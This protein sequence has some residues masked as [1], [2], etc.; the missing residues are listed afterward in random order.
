[1]SSK[2]FMFYVF[3]LTWSTQVFSQVDNLSLSIETVQ[4]VYL[5]TFKDTIAV[6]SA[7]GFIIRS[8]TRNYLITNWHVVTNKD[9]V[10][11]NWA[12]GLPHITPNKIRIMHNSKTI[13]NHIV[14][15]ENLTNKNGIRYKQFNINKNEMVDV[16]ALPLTDTSG[17]VAIYPVDYQNTTE[18]IIVRPTE[19]L[20]V[21][22]FPMGIKSAPFFPIWKSGTIASEPDFDQENKPIIWLDIKGYGGMSGAPVYLIT[23]R[24]ITKGTTSINMVGSITFFMGVFSHATDIN[25][26]GIWKGAYLKNIF[27]ELP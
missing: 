10:T 4:S 18:S 7:T 21:L 1:M 23:D 19:S 3:L 8:K 20:Y 12:N 22:G 26:G 17:G 14:R 2:R 5:E 6:S 24:Y 16:I 11:Q 25:I 9:P 13:G 27:N 15:I